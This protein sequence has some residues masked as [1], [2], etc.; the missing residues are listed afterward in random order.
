[1]KYA[2]WKSDRQRE[3]IDF[4]MA[5]MAHNF[6]FLFQWL[7]IDTVPLLFFFGFSQECSPQLVQ[8]CRI[9]RKP[10]QRPARLSFSS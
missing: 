1:M 8:S 10:Q 9:Q 3:L 5:C 4:R 6:K 7:P 2:I